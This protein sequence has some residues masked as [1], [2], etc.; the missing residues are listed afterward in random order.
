MDIDSF[1]VCLKTE[2]VYADIAKDVKTKFGTLNYKAKCL[3][4]KTQQ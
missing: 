1:I 4:K 3:E 2:L